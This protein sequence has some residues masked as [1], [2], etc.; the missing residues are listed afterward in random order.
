MVTL[1]ISENEHP[2]PLVIILGFAIPVS[3]FELLN[4]GGG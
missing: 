2:R 4:I 3:G 1:F